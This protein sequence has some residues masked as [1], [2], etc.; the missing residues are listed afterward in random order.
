MHML[1]EDLKMKIDQDLDRKL[2]TNCHGVYTEPLKWYWIKH[3]DS[4]RGNTPT[5]AS[6]LRNDWEYFDRKF[7]TYNQFVT[8]AKP[9]TS[10]DLVN[11]GLSV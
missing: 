11:A 3:T 6:R 5:L 1:V 4:E 7:A 2:N 8:E 9:A 10:K